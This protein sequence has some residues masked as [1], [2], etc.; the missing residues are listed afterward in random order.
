MT[1]VKHIKLVEQNDNDVLVFIS[2]PYLP[3]S[4]LNTIKT[5][6]LPSN[7]FF[8]VHLASMGKLC[9]SNSITYILTFVKGN[10]NL[11]L[12]FILWTCANEGSSY[13]VSLRQIQKLYPSPPQNLKE[14]EICLT[15]SRN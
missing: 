9:P 8:R 7:C 4:D 10:T 12:V 2:Y 15:G 13:F 1:S 11:L 5:P 3:M 14:R 6:V